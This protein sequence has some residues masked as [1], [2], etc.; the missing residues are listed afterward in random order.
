MSRFSLTAAAAIA[1]A[2]GSL[3]FSAREAVAGGKRCCAPPPIEVKLCVVDPCACSPCPHEVCVCVPGCCTE[4]PTVCW[5]DGFL[6][7]RVATYTWA[8][9]GHSV[10][11][12]ITKHDKVIVRG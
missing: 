2:V 10:D 12:V 7:R 11:V 6:G 8:C 1:V 4:T 5:H 9:C 3:G